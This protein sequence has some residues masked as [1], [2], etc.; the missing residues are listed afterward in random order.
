MTKMP[1]GTKM[2]QNDS[3]AIFDM[4]FNMGLKQRLIQRIE[5]TQRQFQ[6]LK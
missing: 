3:I 4:D 2:T 6:G 5:K 1:L